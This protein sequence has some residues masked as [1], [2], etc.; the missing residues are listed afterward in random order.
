MPWA[1]QRHDGP[2]YQ[3]NSHEHHNGRVDAST[4]RPEWVIVVGVLASYRVN[5]PKEANEAEHRAEQGGEQPEN[6]ETPQRPWPI[7]C[8]AVAHAS[9]RAVRR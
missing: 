2:E 9:R 5:D 1:R 7:G 6:H 8:H 3:R 4:W